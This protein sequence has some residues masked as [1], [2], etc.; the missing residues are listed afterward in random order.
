MIR[1][2]ALMLLSG[3]LAL[4]VLPV[5]ADATGGLFDAVREGTAAEVKTALA[6]GADPNARNEDGD[7][8]L[9]LAAMALKP[10]AI[11]A[12]LEGGADAA[13]R[14][15]DGRVPF[16]YVKDHDTMKGTEAYRLLRD[17]RFK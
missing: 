10:S 4:P 11:L 3:A 14:N 1:L 16:D 17:G 9:H 8:P 5:H 7:T 15:E 2:L 12:L 13:A 6:A